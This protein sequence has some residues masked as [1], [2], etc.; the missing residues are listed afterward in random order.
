MDA[1]VTRSRHGAA[2]RG[3]VVLLAGLGVVALPEHVAAVAGLVVLYALAAVAVFAGAVNVVSALRVREL[4][5]W[6]LPASVGI[7]VLGLAVLAAPSVLGSTLVRVVGVT[8]AVAGGLTL[9]ST[10]CRRRELRWAD[11]SP[12]QAFRSR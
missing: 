9:L 12:R 3:A 6:L 5:R 11:T 8:V 10:F 4:A 7:V 2:F 1:S